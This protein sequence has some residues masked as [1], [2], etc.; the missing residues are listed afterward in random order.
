MQGIWMQASNAQLTRHTA[1]LCRQTCGAKQGIE[2]I[3]ITKW[4]YS[5][6]AQIFLLD[7]LFML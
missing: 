4:L 5:G 1:Q 3:L 7:I 2:V 6:V